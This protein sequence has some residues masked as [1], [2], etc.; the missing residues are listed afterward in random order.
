MYDKTHYNKKNKKFLK[1]D[2]VVTE[3]LKLVEKDIKIAII[4]NESLINVKIL[5]NL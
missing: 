1:K 3:M 4:I 5:V 2:T